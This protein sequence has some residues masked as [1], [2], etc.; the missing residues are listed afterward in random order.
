MGGRV[1]WV[2][3]RARGEARGG[4]VTFFNIYISNVKVFTSKITEEGE[5][6]ENPKP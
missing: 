3:G 4:L 6:S 2:D 5:T 1:G